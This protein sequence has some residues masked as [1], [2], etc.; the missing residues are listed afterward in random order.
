MI[1]DI[2]TVS[3]I[4]IGNMRCGKTTPHPLLILYNIT[5]PNDRMHLPSHLSLDVAFVYVS[6]INM[7]TIPSS[8]ITAT[9]KYILPASLTKDEPYV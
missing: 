7:S 8:D 5:L 2:K 6:G 4:L 9:T 1:P 3:I